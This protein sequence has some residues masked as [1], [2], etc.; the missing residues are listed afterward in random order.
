MNDAGYVPLGIVVG[1]AVFHVGFVGSRR[2]NVELAPLSEALLAAREEATSRMR[3]HAARLAASGIIGVKVEIS[4]FEDR[5]HLARVVAIGTAVGRVTEIDGDTPSAVPFVAGLSGQ[6]FS[7]LADG[8]YEPI[9]LVMGVCMFHIARKGLRTRARNLTT[10]AELTNYT[11]ALYEARELAMR[12]LQA[13]ALASGGEG[14]V[15][16]TISERSHTWGSHA[17]EFFCMGTAVRKCREA[18]L[19][20]PTTVLNI[21]DL[22]VATDP[23]NLHR[24]VPGGQRKAR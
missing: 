16:V 23:A 15:G 10:T 2:A 14:V 19:E 21:R 17:I 9:N 7:V 12:R 8:G 11:A 6:E 13:E 22:Q 18:Q 24:R 1:A 3:E 5:R 20:H 4:A